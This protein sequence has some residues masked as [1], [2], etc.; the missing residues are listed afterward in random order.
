LKIS[1]TSHAELMRCLRGNG[2]IIR[3]D[4]FTIHL[5]SDIESLAQDISVAYGDFSLESADV[6]CDFHLQIFRE[7]GVRKWF[8][9]LARFYFDSRPSF[10]P[11]PA[12]QAFTMFEWGLNWCIAAH[13]HQYLIIHAAVVER[14]GFAAIIPAPP[15]SGK[16]TL[17]AAL[18]QH[19][20]RL[21]S[22]E[23]ALLDINSLQVFGMA[24]PVNLKNQSIELIRQ[25][26]PSSVF[27]KVVPDTTKGTI[28]L[29]KPPRESV[30][31]VKESAKPRWI[32]VPK[33]TADSKP[34]LEKKSAAE[35]FMLIAEQA[36]NYDVHGTLG[37]ETVGKLLDRCDTLQFT[38]SRLDDAV[39]VFDQLAG[40]V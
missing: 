40:A 24:R 39:K 13:C 16:S 9:P 19:G 18:I 20:W 25:F 17:C 7:Q 38:Y 34:F 14:N 10:V 2:L 3:V 28:G 29:L 23:L 33:Y 36:F 31:R 35:T 22:D 27:S 5:K 12:R 8:K 30:E 32:I 6:F 15:G 11:L 21:L 26:E 37:F 1:E 4:P